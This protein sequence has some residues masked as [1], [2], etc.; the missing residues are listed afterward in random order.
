MAKE[1]FLRSTTGLTTLYAIVL[2]R[3]TGYIYDAGDMAFEIVGTYDDARMDECD[4][5]LTEI[6][7]TGWYYADFPSYDPGVH[8]V[9]IRQRAGANPAT[10][11]N[12][13]KIIG[14]EGAFAIAGMLYDEPTQGQPAKS[15]TI[16]ER[17]RYMYAVWRNKMVQV[18]D[19]AGNETMTV[20]ADDDTTQIFKL[21]A[22][23]NETTR[24]T[25]K[26]KYVTGT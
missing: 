14:D 26:D 16:L 8:V 9:E 20:F 5:A 18:S 3:M 10:T 21:S 7:G 12:V 19:G 13:V 23:V 4:I 22:T 15:L 1:I 2:N 25:T 11:D 17:L 6:A 24:T